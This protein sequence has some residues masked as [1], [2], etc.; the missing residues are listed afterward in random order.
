MSPRKSILASYIYLSTD[1]LD[2]KLFHEDPTESGF[3]PSHVATLHTVRNK[4]SG[5]LK[6]L[7]PLHKTA[8]SLYATSS[9]LY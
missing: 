6:P 4:M 2:P 9:D 7:V 5:L 3:I 1:L 8:V